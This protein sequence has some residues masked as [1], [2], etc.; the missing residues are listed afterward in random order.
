M[1][2]AAP[3]PIYHGRCFCGAVELEVVG[4]PAFV[5]YCHCTDCRGWLGAPVHGAAAWPTEDVRVTKGADNLTLY[6][7]TD[8]SHRQSCRTCGG[9]VMNAHPGHGVID[10]MAAIMPDFPFKPTLH[11]FYAERMI[12]MRDGLHKFA[13]MPAEMGGS[14]EL[15]A[16]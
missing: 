3:R 5:G 16:E 7:K 4:D 15:L 14:G 2:D 11:V 12:S 10:V 13:N 8:Q 6:K 1:T 9:S